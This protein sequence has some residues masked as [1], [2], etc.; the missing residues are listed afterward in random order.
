[1]FHN[2]STAVWAQKLNDDEPANAHSK[3]AFSCIATN[4]RWMCTMNGMHL[5]LLTAPNHAASFRLV[6]T[7]RTGVMAVPHVVTRQLAYANNK[8][9]S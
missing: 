2:N 3:A 7:Q 9:T 5:S 6:Q 1:L 8:R 4:R